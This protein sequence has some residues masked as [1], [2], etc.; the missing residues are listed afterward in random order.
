MTVARRLRRAFLLVT[1]VCAVA[2]G[3]KQQPPD[4]PAEPRNVKPAATENLV[5]DKTLAT[6]NRLSVLARAQE[7]TSTERSLLNGAHLTTVRAFVQAMASSPE[8]IR[9]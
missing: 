2:C 5:S 9:R 8:A 3:A 4:Q 6:L 7:L 1:V